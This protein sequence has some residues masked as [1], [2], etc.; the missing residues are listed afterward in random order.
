MAATVEPDTTQ[1]LTI[2]YEEGEDGWIT[3]TIE[4]EPAAIS[5]GRTREEAYANVLDALHDLK[6]QPTPLERVAFALQAHVVEPLGEALQ[7]RL[8]KR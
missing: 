1:H 7:R 8:A 2:H 3:A 5:Q 4:Q 6:H